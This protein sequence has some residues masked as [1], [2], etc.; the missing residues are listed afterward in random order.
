[1]TDSAVWSAVEAASLLNRLSVKA[2]DGI[3]AIGR[4][5]VEDVRAGN[6]IVLGEERI[7]SVAEVAQLVLELAEELVA[8]VDPLPPEGL[9]IKDGDANPGAAAYLA[10]GPSDPEGAM[11]AAGVLELVPGCEALAQALG[12]SRAREDWKDITVGALLQHFRGSN[13]DV[14]ADIAGRAGV[15]LTDVFPDVSDIDIRRLAAALETVARE[16]RPE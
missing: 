11:L 10:D 9:A 6:A 16:H 2:D 3:A 8:V 14:A 13:A 15:A 7:A 1:V 5:F 4:D 12:L